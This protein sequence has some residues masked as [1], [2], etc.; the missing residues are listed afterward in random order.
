MSGNGSCRC[1][2]AAII[3]PEI[4]DVWYCD[5]GKNHVFFALKR[6]FYLFLCSISFYFVYLHH[7]HAGVFF[8]KGQGHDGGLV[9]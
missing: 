8:I 2:T 4:G 6:I 1:S 3:M 5:V 9:S 7:L